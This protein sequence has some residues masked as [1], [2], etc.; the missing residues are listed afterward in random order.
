VLA[1]AL[2]ERR[3]P[4]VVVGADEVEAIFPVQRRLRLRTV[5]RGCEEGRR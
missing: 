5:P 4:L 1:I 3:S 2:D